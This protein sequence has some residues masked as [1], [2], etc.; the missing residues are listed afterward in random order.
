M[1]SLTDATILIESTIFP[2]DLK[3]IHPFFKD[4]K[5]LKIKWLVGCYIL[6]KYVKLGLIKMFVKVKKNAQTESKINN[7][8][9]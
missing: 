5:Y 9:N 3:A 4:E 1:K 7:H 8:I 6:W 2:E